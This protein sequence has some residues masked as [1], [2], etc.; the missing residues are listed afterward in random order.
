ME[1]HHRATKFSDKSTRVKLVD[2]QIVE[3]VLVVLPLKIHVSGLDEAYPCGAVVYAIPDK[4]DCIL[5]I[6]FFEDTQPQIDWRGRRIEGT[7]E[8][9]L[10]WKLTG[11]ICGPIEEGGPVIASGL[12]RSVEAKGLSGKDPIPVEAPRWKRISSTRDKDTVVEKMFTMGVVDESRVPTKFITRNK[13]RKFLRIKT[14]S[15]NE[16]DFMLELSNE[17]IKQ[18]A[19]SLQRRD[20]PDNVGSAKAQRYPETNWYNFRENPAFKLLTEYKDDVFR[21]ELPKG[22]PEKLD[23]EH[24]IDVKDPN[25]AKYRQQ[26]RQSPERQREIVRWVEDM[27]KKKLI[28]PSI[29]PHAAPTF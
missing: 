12:R 5:G 1:H 6:P 21:P 29:T 3:A 2:N 8:K 4:F 23:I 27:V 11:D 28:R 20:Q 7:R 19:R 16:P 15:I 9:T 18:V 26:W 10:C 25:L 24:R 14:K 17:T 13:L 22:L